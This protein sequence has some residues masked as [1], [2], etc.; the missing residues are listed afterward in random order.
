MLL[1]CLE[2]QLTAHGVTMSPIPLEQVFKVLREQHLVSPFTKLVATF[3]KHFKGSGLSFHDL[4]RR[5][6]DHRDRARSQAFLKLFRPIYRRYQQELAEEVDF[7]DMLNRATDH[8][9]ARR[10]Q[11]PFRYILVDEFQDISPARER[12]LKA[13]LDSAP[14]ARLFAVGDDWQ[15]I[16]RFTGSDVAIM[17]DFGKRFKPFQ[18]R[19]LETTFRCS[20]RLARVA[21]DFVLRNPAQIPKAVRARDSTVRP[22]V[23]VGLP[24]DQERPLLQEAL[25]RIAE[26]AGGYNGTSDVLLI[27]R[28]RHQKPKDLHTLREQH[29][30]LRLD[31]KTAHGSKGRQADYVVIL[32]LCSGKYGFPSEMDDD[33]LLDLVLS[34]PEAHPNAEE[35]RLLYVAI[36]RARRQAFLL[37]DGDSPSSFVDELI[38]SNYDVAVF[39]RARKDDVSCPRCDKGRLLEKRNTQDGSSF[40]GCSNWPWCECKVDLCR[41]CS[42]GL[43]VRRGDGHRC[44]HCGAP[45]D[46]CPD[47]DGW[48]VRRNGMHGLFLG[49]SSWP[50]CDFT[51]SMPSS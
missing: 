28:Y 10:F 3:L 39:G 30:D 12:L 33:P 25:D 1:R 5:A 11:S 4:N 38:G 6:A 47:C 19:Y 24:H 36:T 18:R 17:R 27:S 48:L 32:S 41:N 23:H 46:S 42:T 13:L 31:W 26:H 49:C 2:K 20:D 43:P 51:R 16:Y 50:H 15:A 14:G 44:R 22:S 34:R 29:P 8:V 45:H 21:T 9:E 35:R 7:E 40:Y 37:A